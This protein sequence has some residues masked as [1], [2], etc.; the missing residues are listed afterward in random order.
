MYSALAR[1]ALA[2]ET[3]GQSCAQTFHYRGQFPIQ[4]AALL[5]AAFH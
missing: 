3:R 1:K 4:K 2:T 5:P